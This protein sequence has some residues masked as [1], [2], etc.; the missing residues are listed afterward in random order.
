VSTTHFLLVIG[1]LGTVFGIAHARHTR[2]RQSKSYVDSA[3]DGELRSESFH[4]GLERNVTISRLLRVGYARS[5]NLTC[6]ERAEDEG[7]SP[8]RRLLGMSGELID[9]RLIVEEFNGN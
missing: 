9:D 3:H 5:E 2:E 6:Q 7:Q 8:H 1:A 4:F